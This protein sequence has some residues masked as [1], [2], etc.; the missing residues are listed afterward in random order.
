MLSYLTLR[1]PYET[2][3]NMSTLQ[4]RNGDVKK[5]S[6]FQLVCDRV[7]IPMD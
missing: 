7:G 6:N 2:I 1:Q 4:Q 3:T 5:L